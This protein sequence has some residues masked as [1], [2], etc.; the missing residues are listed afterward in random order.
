VARLALQAA[1]CP[2]RGVAAGGAPVVHG[3]SERAW[4]G[5][6]G[7]GGRGGWAGSH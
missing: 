5:V 3:G 1:D 4:G 2:V 7:R 6:R